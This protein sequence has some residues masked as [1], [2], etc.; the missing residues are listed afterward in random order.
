M[1][2]ELN[3]DYRWAFLLCPNWIWWKP[4]FINV[5]VYWGMRDRVMRMTMTS[6][7]KRPSANCKCSLLNWKGSPASWYPLFLGSQSQFGIS[8]SQPNNIK[9]DISNE[10]HSI[11]FFTQI[12]ALFKKP[13]CCILCILLVGLKSTDANNIPL[14]FKSFETIIKINST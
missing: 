5:S 7:D 12:D 13:L 2:L 3:C 10:Y 4:I 9:I 6:N 11:I 8:K 14:L 1:V